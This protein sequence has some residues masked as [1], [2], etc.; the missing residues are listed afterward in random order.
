MPERVAVTGLFHEY[1]DFA[2]FCNHLETRDSKDVY[3]GSQFRWAHLKEKDLA[4]DGASL[5]DAA[6]AAM[7][8]DGDDD[9]QETGGYD[10]NVFA[11][12]RSVQAAFERPDGVEA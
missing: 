2:A 7:T 9:D 6:A 1:L 4:E 3:D 5:S 12:R 8:K 10:D 11:F